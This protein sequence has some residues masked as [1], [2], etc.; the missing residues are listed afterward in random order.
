MFLHLKNESLRVLPNYAFADG[1]GLATEGSVDSNLLNPETFKIP[2]LFVVRENT[3]IPSWHEMA[4][5][6]Q[7][8]L[9]QNLLSAAYPECVELENISITI[10]GEEEELD[11]SRCMPASGRGTSNIPY[12]SLLYSFGK[13]FCSFFT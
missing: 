12:A 2:F 8:E 3:L 7:K 1:T 9:F 6:F 10:Q 13:S 5:F 11:I 4:N